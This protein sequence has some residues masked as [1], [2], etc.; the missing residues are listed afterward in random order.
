MP[1]S[2]DRNDP[3]GAFNFTV[4]VDGVTVAGFSEVS[5][6]TSETDVVEYRT[7][8]EDITVRKLPGLKKFT[9]IVLKRGFTKSDDLWQ[10]RK[11]VMDGQTERQSG[12]IVLRNEAREAAIKWTFREGWPSKWEGPAFNAKTSEVAIETLEIA[13]ETLELELA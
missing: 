5:G 2:G 4:E 9:N 6:L 10:W 3:Y 1:E 11:A 12:T 7:G 13:C 8:P